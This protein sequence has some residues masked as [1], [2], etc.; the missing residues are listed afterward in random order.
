MEALLHDDAEEPIGDKESI[1]EADGMDHSSCV[2]EQQFEA[3]IVVLGHTPQNPSLQEYQQH[4]ECQC[5][6]TLAI[7]SDHQCGYESSID[8]ELE[9]IHQLLLLD[10]NDF[11]LVLD[12]EDIWL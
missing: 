6:E 4:R 5:G 2:A 3:F 12:L 11:H 8:Y 10:Q 1:D 9:S 7:S